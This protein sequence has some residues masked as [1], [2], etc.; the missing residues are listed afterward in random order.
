MVAITE[1]TLCEYGE[2]HPI[3]V[4]FSFIIGA[5]FVCVVGMVVSTLQFVK[6][7]SK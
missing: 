2:K 4:G 6:V 3:I 7:F 5:P 1:D